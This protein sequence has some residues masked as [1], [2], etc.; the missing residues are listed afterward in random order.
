MVDLMI[1]IFLK[2]TGKPAFG[3][4]YII[5]FSINNLLGLTERQSKSYLS[6]QKE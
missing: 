5:R 3:E 2:A 6:G 4:I 1:F